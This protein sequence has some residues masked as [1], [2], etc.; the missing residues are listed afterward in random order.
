MIRRSKVRR[1]AAGVA[2]ALAAL[3]GVTACTSAGS[4]TNAGQPAPTRSSDPLT[5]AAH[6]PIDITRIPGDAPLEP[7]R[8]SMPFVSG[9]GATRAVVE[10]PDG[11]TNHFAV[12]GSDDGDL[13]FWGRVTR[14]DTDP[15]LGGRRVGAGRSVH[16]L[17]SLLVAQR[18]MKTSRPVP[19]TI[20]GYHGVYLQ[21]T[22][23]AAVHRCRGGVVTMYT[24]G[25]TWLQQD[26]PGALFQA[27]ILNVRGQ[28]V[29]GGTRILP[30]A[31][32]GS[33]LSRM[34]SS[35]EF[36]VVGGSEQ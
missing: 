27:W 18:H 29:V 16:D 12:I 31:A 17:A 1:R 36:T 11:Y 2:A 35:A 19:V 7:G 34:V 5:G 30:D 10:V 8:Y 33:E 6:E 23:P 21:S 13:A 20:D 32:N 22:V 25:G 24:D 14:V 28:R 26:V 9:D 15:C 4:A 3:A